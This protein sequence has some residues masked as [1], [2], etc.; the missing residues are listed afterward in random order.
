MYITN[1]YKSVRKPTDV[2]LYCT[3]FGDVCIARS[4]A[5]LLLVRAEITLN[6]NMVRIKRGVWENL[7]QFWRILHL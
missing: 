1:E 5:D 2:S 3:D 7:P 4:I 6:R